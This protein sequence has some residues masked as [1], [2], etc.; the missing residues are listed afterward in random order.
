MT[1]K[2]TKAKGMAFSDRCQFCH[3]FGEKVESYLCLDCKNKISKLGYV[4]LA[5]D[6]SFPKL[7]GIE[8]SWLFMQ[9]R[10][11]QE[12]MLKAGWRKVELGVKDG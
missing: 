11:A 10:D 9:I 5:E 6:Q 4:K 3:E 12:D 2:E 8:S 1:E 7:Y